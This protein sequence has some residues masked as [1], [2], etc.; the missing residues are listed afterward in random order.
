MDVDGVIR[1]IHERLIQV[2]K[3]Y[4]LEH[5]VTPIENWYN[6]DVAEYFPI[7]KDIYE[8]WFNLHPK[9]IYLFAEHYPKALEFMQT[10]IKNNKIT[11]VTK[12]PYKY[13]EELTRQWLI[14]NKIPYDNITFT[15]NKGEFEGDYIL[16]DSPTDLEDIAKAGKSKPVCM[17]RSWNRTWKGLRVYNYNQFLKLI[18]H[19]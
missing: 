9:E 10:I 16:E 7:R 5:E 15:Q 8:F 19:Q 4:Y 1:N 2:Y 3:N 14:K 12:Q 11:I 17:N 18:N 13:L 6:Y